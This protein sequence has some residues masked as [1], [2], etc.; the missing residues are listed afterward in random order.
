[1]RVWCSR[2]GATMDRRHVLILLVGVIAISWAAP[3]IRLAGDV[4]AIVIAAMRLSIA[5]PP[6]IAVAAL[7]RRGEVG[8]LR[9]ADLWLLLLAGVA[10]AGHF[11]FWVAS[12]QRTSVL[13]SVALVT[14]Q[15]IF[16]A[17]GAWI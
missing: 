9:R 8:T 1:R 4:P 5:A 6:M 10:L 2:N 12:L 3:L 13:A 17:L 14:T 11:G 7:T 16:V 15:P